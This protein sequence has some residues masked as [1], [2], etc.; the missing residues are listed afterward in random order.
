MDAI[1]GNRISSWLDAMPPLIL[2]AYHILEQLHTLDLTQ[3]KKV[4]DAAIAGIVAHAPRLQHVHL[5]GCSLLTNAA[6]ERLC[7]LA[8]HLETLTISHA[9]NITDPAIVDLVH[10]CPKLAVVD[11]SCKSRPIS[12]EYETNDFV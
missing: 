1:A 4:T 11:V 2:P 5:A 7:S 8:T 10:C 12:D 9:E 3:C 6:L